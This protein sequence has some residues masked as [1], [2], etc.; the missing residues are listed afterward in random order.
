VEFG[1]LRLDASGAVTVEQRCSGWAVDQRIRDLADT[2]PESKLVQLLPPTPGKESRFLAK[3]FAEKDP[4]ACYII[5]SLATDLAFALSHV[6]HLLHPACLVLGGGLAH[7]GEP[8]RGAIEE[9]LP[10]YVMKAFHPPPP[11]RLTKLGE[12]AV[13]MGALLLAST[14]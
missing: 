1:H 9:V 14:L 4:A 6:V 10:R 2:S 7:V 11:L 3:A 12:S 8:L 13:P 5:A